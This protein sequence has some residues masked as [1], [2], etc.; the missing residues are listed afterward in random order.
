MS[1]PLLIGPGVRRVGSEGAAKPVT[2]GQCPEGKGNAVTPTIRD[3]ARVAGVST[4]SVSRTLNGLESVDPSIRAKVLAAA[5]Q[6]HY[7]ITP[8][9][10]ALSTG[11][12]KCVGVIT[13]Y[14]TRWS[15][16]QLMAGI[17][18]ALRQ[19]D[20]DVMLHCIGDP[21]D[22][23]PAPAHERLRKKVDGLLVMSIAATS[24][25]LD[26]V[27]TLDLP[28]TLLGTVREGV[29]SVS[30]DDRSAAH[31]ATRHL[32]ERGHTSIGIIYGRAA[33][34]PHVLESERYLG[35]VDALV[36][37]GL[38]PDPALEVSGRYTVRGGEAAMDDLL[39]RDQPPTAV[40]AISDEMA[41]GAMRA[42]RARGVRPGEDLALV[43]FDN[44]DLS[45]TLDL[46]TV[47]QPLQGLGELAMRHIL[48]SMR[49][50]ESRPP[51]VTVL[52]TQLLVRASSA[53]PVGEMS[54]RFTRR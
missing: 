4:A 8:A 7:S 36:E 33:H 12:T 26:G 31:A 24:S 54:D 45:E 42:M 53:R 49:A 18:E 3:V 9:A 22:P 15:F 39:S 40:F 2:V 17:Y 50:R 10:A 46:S 5:E 30:I 48:E 23:H 1:V 6:L 38:A 14:V 11:R 16:G 41:F 37:G 25:D 44:H 28:I 51:Q 47:Q 29:S 52:P 43:G 19:T 13:P 21:S 27:L 20:Y 35:F 34:D 32:V